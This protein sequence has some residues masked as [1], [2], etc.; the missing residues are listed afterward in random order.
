VKKAAG[1]LV[2]ITLAIALQTTL[3]VFVVGGTVAVD[4]VLVAV[5]YVALTTGPVT[6]MITGS[7]AG[8]IQDALSS[9][10]IGIGGLAKSLVGFLAG[11]F[12]QQFIA[13]GTVPRLVV[14][15]CATAVHAL[16]FMG[17]YRALGLRT[18]ESPWAAMSSQA[19]GNMAVGIV[20]FTVI[21][22]FPGM[23]ERR[24]LSRRGR[25]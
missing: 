2:A 4:L 22:A 16:V 7:V 20:A 14:F 23:L 24:R 1:V 9:G 3:G 10:L 19:L 21:E 6:G 25:V 17:I 5:A 13:T 18:F 8:L 12:G 11:A 15:F